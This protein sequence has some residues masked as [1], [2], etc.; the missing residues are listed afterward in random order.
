M[1]TSNTN[2]VFIILPF[3]VIAVYVG[4]QEDMSFPMLLIVC[5]SAVAMY[6]MSIGMKSES[7]LKKKEQNDADSSEDMRDEFRV[8]SGNAR[9]MYDYMHKT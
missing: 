6:I 3:L 9:C 8:S 1:D 4:L 2:S 5:I 7:D